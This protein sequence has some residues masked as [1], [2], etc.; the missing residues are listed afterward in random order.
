[1]NWNWMPDQI[2]RPSLGTIFSH[3]RACTQLTA[4]TFNATSAT[5]DQVSFG[6][7][8]GAVAR[9]QVTFVSGTLPAPL[10]IGTVYYVR[11]ANL[12]STKFQLETQA[13]VLVD[14]TGTSS[15]RTVL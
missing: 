6:S 3:C 15:S 5:S 9:Y 14:I 12:T 11:A 7:N 4:S 2:Q 10:Q 8:H 13:G 1:M